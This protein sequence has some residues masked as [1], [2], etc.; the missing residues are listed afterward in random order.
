MPNTWEEPAAS[1]SETVAVLAE[2]RERPSGLD[3]LYRLL[4]GP[5]D[6]THA[7]VLSVDIMPSTSCLSISK[8][9]LDT[10]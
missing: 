4:C 8:D 5:E 2:A 9:E 3:S 10:L 6:A 7:T 1:P